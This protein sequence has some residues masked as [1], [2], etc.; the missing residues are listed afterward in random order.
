[1]LVITLYTVQI[2]LSVYND[3]VWINNFGYSIVTGQV[4]H[5]EK[6]FENVFKM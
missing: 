3:T 1:M 6:F 2:L 5:V 4:G